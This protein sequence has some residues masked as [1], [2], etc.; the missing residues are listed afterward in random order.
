MGDVNQPLGIT[1]INRRQFSQCIA[2]AAAVFSPPLLAQTRT[3]RLVVPFAPGGPTDIVA[4][5]IAEPM[6]RLLGSTVVVDNKAGAGGTLGMAEVA[7]APADGSVLGLA[8]VSTHG[9]N[10]VLYRK[11][12]YDAKQDFAPVSE[13]V[14][15]PVVMLVNANVPARNM[16]EMLAPLTANP[17]KLSYGS[18]GSGTVGHMLT[19]LFKSQTQTF[20]VH[21]PYRGSGPALTDLMAGQIQ[22]YFDQLASALPHIKAGR[23]R[24][25]AVSW[26][27]RLEVLPDV[28]TF[29]EVAL[30]ANN[31]P[32]WFGVVAPAKTPAAEVRRFN[33]VILKALHDTAVRERFAQL[34]LFPS[35]STP[36]A[37]AQT[38][39]R[40]IDTM[41]RV[42]KFAGIEL[43]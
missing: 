28:P 31:A 18:P 38:I 8:T 30:P 39:A 25:L 20:M 41:A 36:E 26:D 11:L 16:A 24:A 4:R 33:E 3:L 23:V 6:S 19:E 1:M 34:A 2:A 12:S 43:E 14:R 22:V 10:P 15:A 37:F 35:G 9:V 21:I 17:G 7:R 13:L 32:T 40:E 27:K 5:A 29:A 42:A